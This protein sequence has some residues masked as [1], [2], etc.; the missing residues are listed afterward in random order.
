M[1]YALRCLVAA[2]IP[3]NQGCMH[4]IK[5]II[6][7]KSFL[8]PNEHAAVAAGNG[9]TCRRVV[10]V[11]FKALEA[12]A[13]SNGCMANFTFGLPEANGFGYYET[14]AGGS[15]AGPGWVGE[16]GVHVHM[17]NTRI[18]DAEIL[19]RRYPVILREYSLRK[20]S[21]GRGM[22]RGGGGVVRELELLIDLHI[23]ILSEGRAFPPYGMTRGEDASTGLNL[24]L[25]GDGSVINV[26][27]KASFQARKGDRFR[28]MTPG[29]GGYGSLEAESAN[30]H[31]VERR[32]E[33][34]DR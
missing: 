22:Y 14:I 27:G 21:G 26:G 8:D 7:E 15:G 13:A 33:V 31:Q 23:G 11:I 3:L 1:I 29:G 19:E 18:T 6:P 24:W 28:I 25:R 16:D 32:Y 9:L 4:T 34:L 17:T 10:D 30:G 2:D 20:G 5:L 12:C